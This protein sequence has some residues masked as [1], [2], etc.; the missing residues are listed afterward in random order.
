MNLQTMRKIIG[1]V[2]A[3]VMMALMTT[4]AAFAQNYPKSYAR[5]RLSR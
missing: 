1:G 2:M 3:V 5:T 4:Q